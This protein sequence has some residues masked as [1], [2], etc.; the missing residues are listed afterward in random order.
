VLDCP[1]CSL[2]LDLLLALDHDHRKEGQDDGQPKHQED[3]GQADRVFAWGEIV[4]KEV[5]LVNERLLEQSNSWVER[6]LKGKS[7]HLA[8]VG[9][10]DARWSAS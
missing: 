1:L 8:R 4:V 7:L 5:G 2:L 6:Q 10:H 3:A 9:V